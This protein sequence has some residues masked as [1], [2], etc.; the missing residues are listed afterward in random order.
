MYITNHLIESDSEI[1]EILSKFPMASTELKDTEIEL[2]FCVMD[3]DDVVGYALVSSVSSI[4]SSLVKL[5]LGSPYR[6]NGVE[7]RL[8][9]YIAFELKSRGKAWLAVN[10]ED[11]S[12]DPSNLPWVTQVV[13]DG[14]A[15]RLII[16]IDGVPARG[17][18]SLAG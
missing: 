10:V 1:K 7:I 5:V 12:L 17:S 13:G 8:L 18:L 11:E 2:F 16:K 9:S 4:A 15:C 3:E 6:G 14:E